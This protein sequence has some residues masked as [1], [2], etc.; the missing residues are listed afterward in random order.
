[1][2]WIKKNPAQVALA[3]IALGVLVFSVLLFQKIGALP[4]TFKA[5]QLPVSM[6]RGVVPLDTKA[7][8]E[9]TK[10]VKAPGSWVFNLAEQG[11][12]FVGRTYI[13]ED[14]TIK[15]PEGG[16]FQPP[17]SNQWL[18]RYGLNFLND[19]VLEEDTDGDGFSNRLE[20]YGMDGKSHLSETEPGQAVAG[21]DG[22]PLP[23]DSTSPI[24]P[25]S[26]P[27]YHTR[28]VLTN[29][30]E[31]PMRLRFM[32]YD[33]TPKQTDVQINTIDRGN[34]THFLTLPA[35]IP[36]TDYRAEK[37]VE[38]F[39]PGPDDTKKDVSE[40]IV[41]NKVTKKVVPLPLGQITN[42][43]ASYILLGY[44]WVPP[45]G[46]RIPDI[47]LKKDE[48]FTLPPEPDKIYK[49]VDIKAPNPQ[50]PGEITIQLPTGG[51]FILR[52]LPPPPR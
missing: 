21:P 52:M 31:I 7:L 16:Y 34:R 30:V 12:L 1:M 43:P 13:K 40:L 19:G 37:V 42:D 33:A 46:Q 17:A 27:P 36:G 39:I 8:D 25:Q 38:K 26:H 50:T 51:T 32:A 48:T 20:F 24:D 22:V 41:T 23:D 35:D 44:L 2:D 6:N 9:A 11:S 3:A 45:G 10:S 5:A 47:N 18:S 14:D 49:V 15:K 28:L 29:V 4:E